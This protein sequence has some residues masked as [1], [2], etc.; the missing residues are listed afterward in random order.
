MT[1]TFKIATWNVNSI[2]IRIDHLLQWLKEHEPDVLVLQELK[3][4]TQLFPLMEVQSAGYHAHVLGQKAYNGVAILSKTPTDGVLEHLPGDDTDVHAR[5]LEV[6]FK[7]VHIG[8]LY[9]PNGNPVDGDKFTYKLQWMDRL[10]LR[11]KDLLRD[12]TPF[13]ML[14]DYNVCPTDDDVHAPEN[15]R[16][17]ALCRPESREKFWQLRHLGLYDAVMLMD[18]KPH[19]FTYWD[20]GR[21]AYQK[22]HG[23]RIDH[24]L[25]SPEVADGLKS[26]TI[27]DGVRG[28]ERPSDHV[29]VE[30]V[31]EDPTL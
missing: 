9:L 19:Q 7:G 27:H 20:Y 3:C 24:L 14:G 30:A 23:L 15:Y 31:I 18:E 11:A 22:N 6:I 25:L 12:E 21:G 29:P 28:W 10:I 17:N 1:E 8:G 2:R 4:E 16:N 13:I 5:Y 26:V